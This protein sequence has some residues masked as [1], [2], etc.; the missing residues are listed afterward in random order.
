MVATLDIMVCV[1]VCISTIYLE[2]Q[3]LLALEV[4]LGISLGLLAVFACF[5]LFV[6]FYGVWR[7][8]QAKKAETSRDY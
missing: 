6:A 8:F 2:R 1:F 5:I 7:Y 3:D 4:N